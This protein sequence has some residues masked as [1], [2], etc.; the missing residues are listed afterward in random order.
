MSVNQLKQV[1]VR[2]SSLNLRCESLICKS[3]ITPSTP[4]A[5][6]TVNQ[7]T[8]I[9]T[10]IDCGAN[11]SRYVIANTQ[12][13][14]AAAGQ[15]STFTFQNTNITSTSVI[16]ANIIAYSGSISFNGL[17]VLCVK[18]ISLGSCTVS[19][20]NCGTLALSGTFA[21]YIEIVDTSNY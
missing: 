2:D 4:Q 6:Q 14:T 7:S 16:L 3:L 18:N 10:T 11:P 13:S 9:S 17:P 21:I 5:V 15:A 1:S 12:S 19:V 8:S 20:M